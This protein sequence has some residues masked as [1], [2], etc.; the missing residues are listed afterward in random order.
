MKVLHVISGISRRAGGPSRSSQGLV[1]AECKAGVDAWIWPLDGAEP[2]IEGVRRVEIRDE[3]LEIR[4]G[5]NNSEASRVARRTMGE[6]SG[7][8][9]ALT[10]FDLVHIH[11]IWDWRL[12]KVA[13]A[14]RKA[15][16]KYIIAPRGMLEP[17]SLKQKWLKKRIAR[18]LY[19]DRDLRGAAALHATAAS[20][21]AQFRA[22]GFGQPVIV[23]PNG[24]NVPREEVC[25]LRSTVCSLQLDTTEG[26]EPGGESDMG[27][28]LG[29]EPQAIC[30][31]TDLSRPNS[32]RRGGTAGNYGERRRGGTAG[33]YGEPAVR[34][35]LFVSRMHKKKGVL[36]LVEAWAKVKK[37]RFGRFGSLVGEGEKITANWF[38]VID[39]EVIISL[40]A[41]DIG[42][43]GMLADR[44]AVKEAFR[45]FGRIRNES[46]GFEVVFPAASAGKMLY[47]SGV[48]IHGI[49]AAFKM[50]FEKSVRAWNE[51]EVPMEGHK[52]HFNVSSYRNYVNKFSFRGVEYYVRFTIR[53]IGS[54]AAVHA[55]TISEVAVYKKTEDALADSHLENPEDDHKASFIDNKI[56]YFLA[57]VNPGWVCELVYTMNS[58]EEREY[59]RKVKERIVELGMS[60]GEIREGRRW[61]VEGGTAEVS[62]SNVQPSTSDLPPDF[63]LTGALDDEKKWDAYYR[64]D[65]FV[66]PTYS[67]NFGIVVAEALWAGVP[68]ITTKGTPWKDLVDH[69]CGWWIEVGVEPLVEALKE[70]MSISPEELREMGH[71]GHVLVHDKYCW[72]AVTRA[73]V[74][75]YEEVISG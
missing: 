56:S 70:A 40:P 5:G 58:E 35:A 25:S 2:W 65:L 60:Y 32:R 55:S 50:L 52:F 44:K 45:A 15:G 39:P 43:P 19:Q 21:E 68:V 53:E 11:G 48:D 71:K 41:I 16:V 29:R 7:T 54:D 6:A 30:K 26:A 9:R 42:E 74:S 4:C 22:L 66:L 38:D 49:A 72:E 31:P 62:N 64:A 18:W 28:G 23:S 73:M 10:D 17:W 12:H 57:R 24:V 1:A 3:R 67:E 33:N 36:E 61:K 59:E 69:N 51:R 34:R 46:D 75:G 27:S 47:Q 63:I 14:C 20:E 8:E 37:E 13:V